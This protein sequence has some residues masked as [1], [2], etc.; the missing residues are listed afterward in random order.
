M[1]GKKT[2]K[3]SAFAASAFKVS[4]LKVPEQGMRH[5]KE[6]VTNESFF[7]RFLAKIINISEFKYWRTLNL[8]RSNFSP[9]LRQGFKILGL[10]GPLKIF[11]LFVCMKA[12]QCQMNL[13]C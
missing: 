11:N 3:T 9:F 7:K 1:H 8:S 2:K 4:Y 6:M 5:K 13:F 12:D 10:A